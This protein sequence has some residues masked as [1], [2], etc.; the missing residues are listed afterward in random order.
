M[1]RNSKK[2]KSKK[3]KQLTLKFITTD[4]WN[5]AVSCTEERWHG[6][7]VDEHPEMTG[8]ENDV[9]AVVNDPATIYPSTL[10]GSSFAFE[11][12][13]TSKEIRVLVQYD[14]PKKVTLGNTSG[15]VQTAYP[16]DRTKYSVPNL[17]PAI[18]QR[19]V[20]APAATKKKE[21]DPA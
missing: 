13:S 14:D 16:V 6:H 3:P 17:G 10:T 9:K 1:K 4:V 2:P 8:L 19:P 11:G 21:G 20:A 12:I 5:C 18:Y 7:I 15:K